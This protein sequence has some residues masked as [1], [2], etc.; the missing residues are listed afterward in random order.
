MLHKPTK[1]LCLN[2]AFMFLDEDF[3]RT[4]VAFEQVQSVGLNLVFARSTILLA[5]EPTLG[6]MNFQK[7]ISVDIV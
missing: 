5:E 1:L 4:D 6:T 2:L 3:D 7:F